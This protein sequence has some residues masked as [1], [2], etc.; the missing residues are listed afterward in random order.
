MTRPDPPPSTSTWNIFL[1]IYQNVQLVELGRF[2][3]FHSDRT[4]GLD[5]VDSQSCFIYIP[6]HLNVESHMYMILVWMCLKF[7]SVHI[8]HIPLSICLNK[9][10]LWR[11]ILWG[12]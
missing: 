12:W 10:E 1:K 4:Y 6:I 5:L 8:G 7:N 3:N 9:F 2:S 11:M